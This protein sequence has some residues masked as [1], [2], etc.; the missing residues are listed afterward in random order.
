[1]QTYFDLFRPETYSNIHIFKMLSDWDCSIVE[2]KTW[3]ESYLSYPDL[4]DHCKA[5]TWQWFNHVQ[6][7]I[8]LIFDFELIEVC[9]V[10]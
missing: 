5:K 4:D 7:S 1:M 6:Q 10:V 3:N 8:L 2:T 9:D